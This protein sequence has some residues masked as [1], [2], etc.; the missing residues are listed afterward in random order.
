MHQHLHPLKE[1]HCSP[2]AILQRC[3]EKVGRCRARHPS[4]QIALS[5]HAC[6]ATETQMI[7]LFLP[8]PLDRPLATNQHASTCYRKQKYVH[9]EVTPS[10]GARA[11]GRQL[12][13][14]MCLYGWTG[15]LPRH[16]TMASSGDSAREKLVLCAQSLCGDESY[17][18]SYCTTDKHAM[19]RVDEIN[20]GNCPVPACIHENV[21][22][23]K[24]W[25]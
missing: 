11:Y 3:C 15:T 13:C 22:R 14:L 1:G 19:T 16:A 25:S 5:S 24:P 20:N 12:I 10:Y 21:P 23:I 9:E 17:S 8:Y 4:N 18:E 6:G 7:P 2:L